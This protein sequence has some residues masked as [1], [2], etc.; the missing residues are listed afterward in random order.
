[1]S[2]WVFRTA[3]CMTAGADAARACGASAKGGIPVKDDGGRTSLIGSRHQPK[4]YRFRSRPPGAA[5]KWDSDEGRWA[6]PD[7]LGSMHPAGRDKLSLQVP[8]P[9]RREETGL[10]RKDDGGGLNDP[11]LSF[12][13]GRENFSP[14]IPTIPNAPRKRDSDERTMGWA[15]R[16]STSAGEIL[17]L[18]PPYPPSSEESRSIC[19]TTKGVVSTTWATAKRDREK[20]SL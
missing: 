9:Q 14:F 1:M 5:R 15:P 17:P 8:T 10:R 19:S 12:D 4:K 6:G 11:G 7:D 3:N 13:I 16:I 2:A 18:S 20:I